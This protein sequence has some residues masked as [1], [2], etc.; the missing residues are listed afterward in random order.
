MFFPAGFGIPVRRLVVLWV[1][2]GL[3]H[4]SEEVPHELV[5]E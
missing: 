3:V 4:H 1:A 5:A 2:V